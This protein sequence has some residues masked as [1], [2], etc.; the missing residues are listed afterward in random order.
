MGMASSIKTSRL[1]WLE[2]R[3]DRM[4]TPLSGSIAELEYDDP[5]AMYDILRMRFRK[6]VEMALD[7]PYPK[8]ELEGRMLR[9]ERIL[10]R[11]LCSIFRDYDKLLRR[12]LK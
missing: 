1:K 2:E 8:K 9:E 11:Y 7:S 10:Y 4:I 6:I 5:D 3:E 12:M